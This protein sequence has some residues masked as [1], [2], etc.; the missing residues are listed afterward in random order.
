MHP[1]RAGDIVECIKDCPRPARAPGPGRDLIRSR[2]LYRV[3]RALGDEVQ[4]YG[5]LLE[6][7]KQSPPGIGWPCSYFRKLEGADADF[8][9]LLRSIPKAR[10]PFEQQ[11]IARLEATASIEGTDCTYVP[12]MTA[13]FAGLEYAER[14]ARGI[15]S[16][17]RALHP[18]RR[19]DL[20]G[21]AEEWQTA[22][23]DESPL[24]SWQVEQASDGTQ[25]LVPS[26]PPGPWQQP[27]QDRLNRPPD[28]PS[29]D[30]R[31]ES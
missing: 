7:I 8:R 23:P 21:L 27:G 11:I 4:G 19:T 13:N 30:D 5:V 22:L 14:F 25:R 26:P 1:F 28:R 2:R 6:G 17:V 12:G 18:R 16:W 29:L 10:S 15:P 3:R 9:A 24:L 20:Y 31:P